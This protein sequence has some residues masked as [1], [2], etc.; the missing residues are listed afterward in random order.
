MRNLN[1]VP[2][3]LNLFPRQESVRLC[4]HVEDRRIWVEDSSTCFSYKSAFTYSSFEDNCC[5]YM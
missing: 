4:S 3:L 5:I 2:Q 1:R